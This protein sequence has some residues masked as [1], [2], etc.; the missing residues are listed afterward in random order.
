VNFLL[1][2]GTEEMPARFLPPLLDELKAKLRE[3][4]AEERL[5]PEKV[6]VW[7]T[8]RR[9]AC[10]VEG[11]PERQ[12]DRLLAI[13]GPPARV[14]FDEEGRPTRAAEGFA[15]SQGVPV[16]ELRRRKTD[17]G[18][19]IF[20][21]KVEK[22]EQAAAVLARIMPELLG[23]LSF[24]KNMRWGWEETRFGRPV[25]WLVALLGREV[26]SFQ[27]A[28]VRSGRGSRGHRF[29]GAAEIPIPAA[30]D[31]LD[32]M[33]E[34]YVI[35]DQNRR[36]GL[37]TDQVRALAR[38][39]GGEALMP[40]DLLEEVTYLVEYPTAFLGR[41]DPAF[42]EVPEEV[43]ITTMRGHQRYFPVRGPE[44]LLPVFIG[45]RN[46]GSEHLEV[47]RA[48]NE[49]VLRARLA[50]A[51]FFFEEDLKRPLADRVEGLKRVV[52]QED[53]GTLYD[54]S[55][56][57]RRLAGILGE[58][59][60]ADR[61]LLT[62][63]DRAAFLA[64]A[65]LDTHLVYEFPELQ[66]VM[67]REYA[68][69]EGEDE[70]VARA[71]Y[72][73]YLPRFAGDELPET[74]AGTLLSLADKL[75]TIVG[76]F[77]VG[78]QPSGSKD[79]YGLRRQATGVVSILHASRLSLRL[80]EMIGHAVEG[81]PG[82]DVDRQEVFKMVH[83]FF[84]PRVANLLAEQGISPDVIEA[85]LR[86]DYD[87]V[88]DAVARAR[89]VMEFKGRPDM[90]ELL[91]A[92]RRANNLA[93]K[94]GEEE[95]RPELFEEEAEGTLYRELM[96]LRERAQPYLESRDYRSFLETAVGL[97]PVIDAFFD[98]V[99]VMTDDARLRANRLALL[100][101]VSR[102]LGRVADW[103]ALTL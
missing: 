21:E 2:I 92:F 9:I 59:V 94:A 17:N 82:A 30:E 70:A 19:Y 10:Y 43:L 47:V 50:D 86:V 29:A 23:S 52:F 85:V 32:L 40:E 15:R 26:V 97:K 78:I 18:E 95:I 49:K 68:R 27:F 41:F 12:E 31:Y 3:R 14:A 28:G 80:D 76:C 98:G 79:P 36:R 57:V 69:R 39:E 20:A 7:A 63:L 6:R 1:E 77:S 96:A 53:L 56:R 54:K 101:E 51:R 71:L 88:P 67:G 46:G 37:I 33:E 89:D 44:G 81:C 73:Q 8:P 72:E 66:G 35:V 103:D 24:P 100:R 34:N 65:D 83:A 48:G 60:G 64:K 75:D 74:P 42:L 25:R 62:Q 93:E 84:R 91:I 90:E 4:L 99:L 5:A 11:L 13:K 58:K 55:M 16:E 22:G 87:D 38:E 102:F 45:V 61:D